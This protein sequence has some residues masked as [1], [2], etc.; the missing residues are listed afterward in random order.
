MKYC[1]IRDCQGSRFDYCEYV[2][3]AGV[4]ESTVE[5]CDNINLRSIWGSHIFKCFCS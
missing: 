1:H 4:D 3:A 2:T 5:H